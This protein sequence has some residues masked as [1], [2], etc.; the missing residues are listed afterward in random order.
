MILMNS[1]GGHF[2]SKSKIGDLNRIWWRDTSILP[3]NQVKSLNLAQFLTIAYPKEEW[4]FALVQS[5]D[6]P[7]EQFSVLRRRKKV[8]NLLKHV[9]KCV[10]MA[11]NWELVAPKLKSALAPS[12]R[13]YVITPGYFGRTSF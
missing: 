1:K 4:V 13:P 7:L 11:Q 12:V 8:D 3:K 2:Y 10:K 9:R 6:D 5:S